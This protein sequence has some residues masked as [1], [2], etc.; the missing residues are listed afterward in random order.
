MRYFAD[1]E[2]GEA[3]R[4]NLGR[5][6]SEIEAKIGYTILA[7]YVVRGDWGYLYCEVDMPATRKR[8]LLENLIC[9]RLADFGLDL[10]INVVR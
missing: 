10:Q 3:L 6:K 7:A 8:W 5:S 1:E 4:V 9:V 2:N